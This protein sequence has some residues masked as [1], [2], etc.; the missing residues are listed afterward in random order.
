MHK[1]QKYKI[2]IL[3]LI[4]LLI[5]ESAFLALFSIKRIAKKKTAR[6]PV[7]GKP[8]VLKGKIAIVLDDWGYSLNNL[9]LLENIK[10]PLTL[11]ILPNLFYSK[12]VAENSS[13]LG[14]ETI[15]HLP[16]E[17]HEE[18]RLE[19]NTITTAMNETQIKTILKQALESMPYLKG[20]SNHMGSKA[21]E[22]AIIMQAIFEE[23]K[24]RHLYFLDSFV[25]PK[26]VCSVLARKLN[27]KFAR[28][29]IFLDNEEDPDYIKK[30]IY[31][32]KTKARIKGEA[33]GI[34]HD[35]KTTLEVLKEEIPKLE[36][37]GYR[38]V[39]L[40]ELVK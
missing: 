18:F 14:F 17:P 38:F 29:D 33:V 5:I 35:R 3:V 23:L 26:T 4:I 21:T 13:R 30:Q 15:L 34:G 20:A 1:L 19:K 25:S 24:K 6:P 9:M 16:L 39:F 8:A 40:S 31:Q 22:D 28:R 12:N 2:A 10:S 7:S 36:K 11:A 37:E 27:L 32:L